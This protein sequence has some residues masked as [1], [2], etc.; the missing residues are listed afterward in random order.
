[1]CHI[2]WLFIHVKGSNL[3]LYWQQNNNINKRKME[4][5][6]NPIWVF[7][8]CRPALLRP[9]LACRT[10][11]AVIDESHLLCEAH[12]W[13]AWL[14][15]GGS[16]ETSNYYSLGN[17]G[18]CLSQQHRETISLRGC[19]SVHF[20]PTFACPCISE[21]LQ[22]KGDDLITASDGGTSSPLGLRRHL[23]EGGGT[24]ERRWGISSA[25][26]RVEGCGWS[27]T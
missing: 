11:T 8:L 7:T 9:G 4:C 19:V 27:T 21:P 20:L 2:W 5:Q 12:W 25:R 17:G 6:C 16:C 10:G 23:E 1:M 3:G 22:N 15:I 13:A 24:V 26:G 18:C 14:L